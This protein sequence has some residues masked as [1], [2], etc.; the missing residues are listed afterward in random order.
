MNRIIA[1]SKGIKLNKRTV[2]YS[3]IFLTLL[4]LSVGFSAFQNNLQIEDLAASV[5]IEKDIRVAK[6]SVSSSNN[7]VSHYEDYNVSNI[8]SRVT[9]PNI[10][11][12]IIYDIDVYNLGNTIMGIKDITTNNQNLKFEILNYNLKEKLCDD[13]NSCNLGMKKT[14]KLKVSYND[15]TYSSD[16]T[17]FD[18]RC[19]FNFK[20]FHNITYK[21]IENSDK[22]Q[23]YILDGEDLSIVIDS[24]ILSKNLKITV[25][26]KVLSSNEYNY[27][28]GNLIISNVTGNIIIN[29]NTSNIMDRFIP[30]TM[31]SDYNGIT[32]NSYGDGVYEINGTSNIPMNVRLTDYFLIH[33]EAKFIM[34]SSNPND[35]TLLEENKSYKIEVEILSGDNTNSK[36]NDFRVCFSEVGNYV[37]LQTFGYDFYS[38]TFGTE[39]NIQDIGMSMLWI[40]KGVTFNN[41]KFKL[42]IVEIDDSED[43]V[44]EINDKKTFNQQGTCITIVWY[45][46][47]IIE[48]FGVND[49]SV[50]THTVHID[51]VNHTIGNS[52]SA[53]YKDN[54]AT[55]PIYKAGDKVRLTYQFLK[56]DPGIDS[57]KDYRHQLYFELRDT[58]S[59]GKTIKPPSITTEVD[60]F[61]STSPIIKEETLTTDI[62][63][64]VLIIG[65]QI[66]IQHPW[67]FTYKTEKIN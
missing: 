40:N 9:L 48:V 66:S 61:T 27:S 53:L 16:N 52:L 18:I 32:V 15:N 50:T 51:L 29:N 54:F 26:G 58:S 36:Y 46:T 33:N 43:Y 1:M 25:D 44:G 17:T 34:N 19:D 13:N 24:T 7:A 67:R 23:Q 8:T 5:R 6:V 2:V 41:F 65:N 55:S 56:N 38:G 22:L 4:F 3:L 59:S 21:N 63:T 62:G 60:D 31:S 37:G 10:D 49:T 42:N 30:F 47:G 11:S 64:P 12:Y 39:R 28:N 14:L 45:D 20:E 35:K 57:T